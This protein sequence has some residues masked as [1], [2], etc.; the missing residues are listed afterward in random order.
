MIGGISRDGSEVAVR[1]AFDENNG[2]RWR[3]FD[4]HDE[5]GAIC[6][7]RALCVC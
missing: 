2:K 1:K 4:E 7:C 6:C 5:G 3:V